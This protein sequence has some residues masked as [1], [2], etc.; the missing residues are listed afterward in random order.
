MIAFTK[1][2]YEGKEWVVYDPRSD[3]IATIEQHSFHALIRY[4][5]HQAKNIESGDFIVSSGLVEDFLEKHDCI[6]LGEL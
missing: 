3:S 6:V 5:R 2:K 4:K 1:S